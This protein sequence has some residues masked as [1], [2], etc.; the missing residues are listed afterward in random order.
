M[1]WQNWNLLHFQGAEAVALVIW[2]GS[3]LSVSRAQHDSR[4]RLDRRPQPQEE[5][6]LHIAYPPLELHMVQVYHPDQDAWGEVKFLV[7]WLIWHILV[8]H[9]FIRSLW[10]SQYLIASINSHIHIQ[11]RDYDSKLLWARTRHQ[12]RCCH[13]RETWSR[14]PWWFPKGSASGSSLRRTPLLPEIGGWP[15]PI[16]L[17]LSWPVLQ[18]GSHCHYHLCNF[19]GRIHSWIPSKCHIMG[20]LYIPSKLIANRQRLPWPDSEWLGD[21]SDMSSLCP[22]LRHSRP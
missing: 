8:N 12:I 13:R 15:L 2:G 6:K 14:L 11:P 22:S 10:I 17:V 16:V 20:Q 18:S 7:C 5:G 19:C 3:A 1:I 4:R 21:M 9:R